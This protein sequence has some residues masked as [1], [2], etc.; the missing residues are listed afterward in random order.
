M[1]PVVR[2]S[3]TTLLILVV[4]VAEVSLQ[5]EILLPPRPHLFFDPQVP[6]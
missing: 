3:A 1:H 4:S 5:S 2:V 6:R